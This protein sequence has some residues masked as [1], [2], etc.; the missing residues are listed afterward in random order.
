MLK[1]IAAVDRQAL[2]FTPIARSSDVRLERGPRHGYDVMLH[3]Y[4]ATSR[5]IAFRKVG[6][7]YRWIAEQELH[8]G[9]RLWK[10]EDGDVR[11]YI[12]VEYQR[13][14]VDGIPV[15]ELKIAY[16]GDDP[17]LAAGEGLTLASIQPFLNEW[18][19]TQW[20]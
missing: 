9:P 20:R 17:R 2:G 10:T 11:E 4:D 16:I 13:E 12:A 15:N 1:A 8:Y 3:V 14:P 5:T 6:D 7:G 18:K 19:G